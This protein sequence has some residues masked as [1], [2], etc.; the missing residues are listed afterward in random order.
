MNGQTQ[1]AKC[2]T[3]LTIASGSIQ[4]AELGIDSLSGSQA[5]FILLPLLVPSQ[6]QQ[7]QTLVDVSE[8]LAVDGHASCT[9]E[10][11]QNCDWRLKEF[12]WLIA[13][14]RLMS[15]FLSLVGGCTFPDQTSGWC[16]GN[17]LFI[18]H[19]CLFTGVR[20]ALYISA[21]PMR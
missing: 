2:T 9:A 4:A 6:A 18:Q 1:A 5:K 13:N 20:S 15:F 3:L 21:T 16:P 8:K 14:Y 17:I 7:L 12:L 11:I 10:E 19:D